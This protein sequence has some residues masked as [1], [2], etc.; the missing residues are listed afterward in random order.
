LWSSNERGLHDPAIVVNGDKADAAFRCSCHPVLD[1][2]ADVEHLGVEEYFLPFLKQFVE[3]AVAPRGKGEPQAELKKETIPS[4]RLISARASAI[5]GTSSATMSRSAISF[6]ISRVVSNCP[7]AVNS[8]SRRLRPGDSMVEMAP[9]RGGDN[10]CRLP[11]SGSEC[12]A[13]RD[14]ASSHGSRITIGSR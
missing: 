5:E 12:M 3:Q 4:S 9:S 11:E 1:R 2:P 6:G 7:W 10:I 13:A 8:F 14:V